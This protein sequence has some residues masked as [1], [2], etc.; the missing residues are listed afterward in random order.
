MDRRHVLSIAIAVIA[1][2]GGLFGIAPATA[3]A[4]SP[5]VVI[6]GPTNAATVGNVVSLTAQCAAATVPAT[7][8]PLLV[9]LAAALVAA[10]IVI[11]SRQWVIGVTVL[12]VAGF[13]LPVRE[14][15]AQSNACAGVAWTASLGAE[16]FSGSGTGFSFTPTT[17]A[18]YHV[19]AALNGFTA[20][21]D[22]AV[23]ADCSGPPLTGGNAQCGNNLAG[24]LGAYTWDLFANGSSACI[25]PFGVG[26]AYDATWNNSGDLVAREGVFFDQTRTFSQIGTIAVDFSETKTGSAGGFSYI[27]AYGWSNN[28]VHEYYIIDDSFSPLPTTAGSLGPLTT[29]MGT[30]V[31]DGATYSFYT[32]PIQGQTPF[33]TA[34]GYI[35]Y[36]SVRHTARTCGRISVT[37]HFNAWASVGMTLGNLEETT[38]LTETGGGTGSVNFSYGSVT[39][40]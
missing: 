6:V 32:Q 22:I 3:S 33:N 19:T 28:P 16:Q 24:T 21:S 15:S 35:R 38:I 11:R 2:A 29:A 8:L 9:I 23:G 17:Q 12:A 25:T 5:A 1:I 18:T 4:D 10:A 13:A 36:Y 30:A 27:G 34:S 7:P 39:V 37:D 20:A 40:Y 14:V 31:L 26:A